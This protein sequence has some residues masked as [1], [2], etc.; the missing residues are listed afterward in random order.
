MTIYT[1]KK[2]GGIRLLISLAFLAVLAFADTAPLPELKQEA[3]QQKSTSLPKGT[4]QG[5]NSKESFL[6]TGKPS[7]S[8]TSIT[9][10]HGPVSGDTRVL[11][12]GGPFSQY[13]SAYPDPKCRFGNDD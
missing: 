9:P 7:V 5:S 2:Q 11:V 3:I 13:Q 6:K 4:E 1:R 10:S 12:R 8:I